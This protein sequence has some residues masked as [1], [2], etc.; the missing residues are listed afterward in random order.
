MRSLLIV[1]PKGILVVI[2][3]T[4]FLIVVAGWL[5]M[6]PTEQDI[7]A[8]G[9]GIVSLQLAFTSQRAGEILQAWGPE[10]QSAARAGMLRD[11]LYMVGYGLAFASVTLLVARAQSG[12]L[13]R[14]G[15][16]VALMPLAAMFL[17]ALEN[18]LLLSVLEV[19]PPP[20][21]PIL[22]A[23]LS[24]SLKFLLLALTIL[25]W[26]VG[27]AAWVVKKASHGA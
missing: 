19:M 20:S 17:D 1:P 3:I 27:G 15:L 22:A 11:F 9:Y 5:W 7:E 12:W 4:A 25:Y 24:A 8:R 21:V 23:S 14:A 26:A 10:G 6:W 18:G 13:Q 2:A 16:T